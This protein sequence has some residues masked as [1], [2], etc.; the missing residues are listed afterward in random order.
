MTGSWLTHQ[1]RKILAMKA[2]DENKAQGLQNDAG[3]LMLCEIL[4]NR[5]CPDVSVRCGIH[6]A[7][8]KHEGSDGEKDEKVWR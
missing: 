5:A 1:S 4:R 7:D 6:P 3:D 2:T 8:P